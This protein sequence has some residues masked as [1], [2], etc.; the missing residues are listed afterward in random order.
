MDKL[1]IKHL[2]SSMRANN[3]VILDK[4]K[5]HRSVMLQSKKDPKVDANS[6]LEIKWKSFDKEDVLVQAWLPTAKPKACLLFVYGYGEYASKYAN[7]A[8]RFSSSN[9]A[10][11]CVELRGHGGAR[12]IKSIKQTLNRI[13]KDIRVCIEQAHTIC[14]GSPIFLYGHGMGANLLINLVAYEQLNICGLVLSSSWFQLE[15]EF[16]PILLGLGN[17]FKR[18][19]PKIGTNRWLKPEYLTNEL[20]DTFENRNDVNI[21]RQISLGL[22]SDIIKLS[23]KTKNCLYRI[24]VPILVLHGD[25]DKIASCMA[26]REFVQNAGKITQYSEIEGGFHELHNDKKRQLV[27]DTIITWLIKQLT[28]EC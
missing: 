16:N 11:L 9:F 17:I 10:F 6:S 12:N 2:S 27:F 15:K 28:K 26:A 24:N 22:L 14:P 7:W 4:N 23:E 18:F 21:K 8:K 3:W 19:S 25:F 20:K 13:N 5:I 1:L